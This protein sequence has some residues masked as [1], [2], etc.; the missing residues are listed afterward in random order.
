MGKSERKP[1]QRTAEEKVAILRR[2]MHAEAAWRRTAIA[3][4][5]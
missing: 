3:R 2:A 5:R 4:S 1:Q